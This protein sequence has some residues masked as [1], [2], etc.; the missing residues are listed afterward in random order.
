MPPALPVVADWLDGQRLD[1]PL[2]VYAFC[3]AADGHRGG[4]RLL[5]ARDGTLVRQLENR[6]RFGNDNSIVNDSG[7]RILTNSATIRTP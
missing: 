4:A 6:T 5:R 3:L 2:V 1:E 7:S